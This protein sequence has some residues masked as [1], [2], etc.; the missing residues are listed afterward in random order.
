MR[1]WVTRDEEPGGPLSTAIRAAGLTVVHEPVLTRRV[2][3]DAAVTISQLGPDDW[4][5][6]TSVYAVEAVAAEPARVPRVAV[7][8]EPSRRAAEARGFRVELV[9]AGGDGKS[10]FHELRQRATC[11]KVC[12]P[13]SSLASRPEPWPG[14]ELISPILYETVPRDFDRSVIHRVDVVTVTSPSAVDAVQAATKG[15]DRPAGRGKDAVPG[16]SEDDPTDVGKDD[17]LSILR[18]LSFA[19]IGPTT[20]AALRRIGIEP[21]LEAPQRSFESLAQAIAA[22][23]QSQG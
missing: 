11:G 20:S 21:W 12:Y 15:Q 8:S 6:L 4:L 3:D 7:V 23:S 13:R 10:L 5:V 9:S 16:V 18:G 17:L 22:K 1:V 14:V 19:S 2:V